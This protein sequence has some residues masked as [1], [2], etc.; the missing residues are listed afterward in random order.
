V[1]VIQARPAPA[2]QVR[3]ALLAAAQAGAFF[4][5]ELGDGA[6]APGWHSAEELYRTGLGALIVATA[7][8]LGT[9]EARVGAS[10]L[11]QG[12]AARLWS[13]VLGCALLRG[14]IPDLGSLIVATGPPL[15]LGVTALSGWIADSPSHLAAVSAEVVGRQLG[16]LTAALPVPLADGLLEG[17]AASAMA[18][19]LG[20]LTAARPDLAG[21]AADLGRALLQTPGLQDTGVITGPDPARPAGQADGTGQPAPVGLAFRR[22]SCCLY[23][24]VPGGGLCG[25]CGLIRPPASA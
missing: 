3:E 6:L 14:V 7:R 19:A 22:R 1:T 8:Q 17:N 18:G 16:A 21:P 4:R 24:R 23:Y 20:M 10:I 11:Q 15:R 13:P 5:L 2:A 25:D 9:S 12:F